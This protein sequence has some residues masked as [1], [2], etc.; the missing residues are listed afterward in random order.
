MR[1]GAFGRH[2]HV[3][4]FAVIVGEG[5][6]LGTLFGDQPG[7]LAQAGGHRAALVHAV[8]AQ[9][10][11]EA[12][13]VDHRVVEQ[14]AR[15]VMTQGRAPAFVA[16]GNVFRHQRGESRFQGRRRFVRRPGGRA[17]RCGEHSRE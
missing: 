8:G 16:V 3:G 2:R 1:F 14:P 7:G 15:Q 11:I 17:A 13:E 6:A 12:V 9:F 10:G 4:Q 5:E